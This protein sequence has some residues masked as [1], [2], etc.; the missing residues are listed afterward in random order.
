MEDVMGHLH[1]GFVAALGIAVVAAQL[2]ATEGVHPSAAEAMQKFL[3]R[4]ATSHQYS[5]SR[6]LEASGSGLRAWLDVQTQYTIT[7]GLR[8]SV[9]DEGGSRYIRARVLRSLLDE[10]QRLIARGESARIAISVNNYQ[11]SPE[12]INEEGLVVVAL[13]PLR[14]HRSLIIGHM[15]LT[16]GDGD[17]VRIEGRLARNPSF[18][19]TRVHL[20]RSYRRINGVLMPVS[21]DTTAQL[22]LLGSSAMRMT[23]LYSHI[24]G[25]PVMTP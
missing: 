11:F 7:S 9:T 14:K 18:W 10:E 23:Y 15:F 20:V 16:A 6:R 8:Y 12:G 21:L 17:L 3:A 25:Q 24:D 22:R 13:R 2:S 19:L 4:P 1:V 5:A